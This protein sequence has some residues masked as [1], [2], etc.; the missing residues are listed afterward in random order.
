MAEGEE[1]A[2]AGAGGEVWAA[3]P[4][5]ISI[6]PMLICTF[7]F[8]ASSLR[9]FLFPGPSSDL[10]R[11]RCRGGIIGPAISVGDSFAGWGFTLIIAF[12]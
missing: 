3:G 9:S 11:G 10:A 8:G 7:V 5:R 1:G 2:G 6:R 12:S 4:D